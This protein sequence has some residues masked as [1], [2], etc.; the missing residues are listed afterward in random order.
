MKKSLLAL[1][2]CLAL[3]LGVA[4]A[5]PVNDLALGETAIGIH[6]D[7]FYLEHKLDSR[8]TLGLQSLDYAGDADDIYGQFNLSPN[9]RGIIGSRNFDHADSDLYLGVAVDGPL[10]TNAHGYASFI[11]GSDFKELQI[12]ANF[13]LSYNADLNVSYHAYN[14]TSRLAKVARLFFSRVLSYCHRNWMEFCG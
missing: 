1:T 6:N 11:T 12:G 14:I 5:A 4:A 9:L 8:F 7:G 13:P 3:Q 2:A 10:S